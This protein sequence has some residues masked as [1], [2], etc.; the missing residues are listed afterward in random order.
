MK[1]L[2]HIASVFVFLLITVLSYAQDSQE[3]MKD[4][5]NALFEKEQYVEATSLYLR[6]LSLE[7]RS[8]EL[9]YRYGACLLYNSNKKKDA[10]KYLNYSITDADID[11][12]AYFFRGR[13]L[14]LDYQFEE[15]RKQYQVYQKK[16]SAKADDRYDAVRGMAMCNN[17]KKLLT[18]FTDIIVAEKQEIDKERFFDIYSDSKTIGGSILVSDQFQSKLDKKMGHSPIVHYPP[19]AKTIYYSSYGEDLA[20][21]KDIYIC[22]RLPNGKWGQAQL[23]PGHVNTN[24]DE[25]FPY[26]HPSGN[27]LY[28]S[29]TGHNSMGGYDVFMSR[30]NHGDGRFKSPENVDFAIS[31]PDDDL[32][33]VVDSLFENAY[34]ASARQSEAGKLHVYK[35][36]VVRVPIQEIIVMGEFESEIDPGQNNMHVTLLTHSNGNDLG[37]IKTNQKG[38]YSYVF[39]QG[40]KYDYI[41]TL[42]DSDQEYKFTVTLPF[43]DEFRPLKQR[44]V[45]RLNEN[46]EEVIEIENLFDERV[47]GGEALIA[48]VIRKK[49]ELNVNIDNFN[50]DE[51]E[52]DQK[53]EKILADLGFKG[54][55]LREVGIQLETLKLEATQNGNT[56][57][58][59]EANLGEEILMK[60][61]RIVDL[62][63]I[64]K[65]LT[66]KAHE[67]DDPFLKYNLL[68]EAKQKQTEKELLIGDIKGL[69]ELGT[70]IET[71]L[72]GGA[73]DDGP[74]MAQ[75]E[76]EFNKLV[77]EGDEEGALELL[78]ANQGILTQVKSGSPNGMIGEFVDKSIKIRDDIKD[79]RQTQKEY[80][81][82]EQQIEAAIRT[83]ELRKPGARKKDLEKIESEITTKQV[84]LGLVRGG[85][86]K[87]KKKIQNLEIELN[88]TEKQLASFQN[89]MA[90]EVT[91]TVDPNK[92]D[93]AQAE[94]EVISQAPPTDFETEIEQLEE[95]HPE[96][97]GGAPIVDHVEKIK[98]DNESEEE[99]ILADPTLTEL[100]QT[101]RLI[102]NN[103]GTQ[104]EIQQRVVEIEKEL[105]GG[106]NPDLEEEREKLIEIGEE[107]EEETKGLE[108]KAEGI[109]ETTPNVALSPGDVIQEIAPNYEEGIKAIEG[110]GGLTE[111]EKLTETLNAQEEFEAKVKAEI[112]EVE[113]KLAEDPTDPN[114]NG[115][116]PILEEILIQVQEDITQ[117]KTKIDELPTIV[118]STGPTREEVIEDVAPTFASNV[119]EI[120]EDPNTSP[121]DKEIAIKGQEEELLKEVKAKI[122]DIEK[123]VKK[124]PEDEESK[125]ILETLLEVETATQT[126]IEERAK[127]IETLQQETTPVVSTGPTKEEVIVDVAPSFATNVKEI[128]EDPNTSTLEKEIAIKGQEEELLKDVQSKIKDLEKK[129][130][131]NPEDEESKGIL[132]TL[133]EVE[134][135]TKTSIEEIEKTIED[136]KQGEDPTPIASRSQAKE[137]VIKDIDPKYLGAKEEIEASGESP[138]K[139]KLRIAT[140]EVGLLERLVKEK[141]DLEKEIGKNP[142]NEEAITR[143]VTVEQLIIEQESIIDEIRAE[144]LESLTTKDKED[145][146]KDADPS[147]FEEIQEA[148]NPQEVIERENEL[149]KELRK[150]IEERE[151]SQLRKYSVSVDLELSSFRNLLED[152][153]KREED[154]G[155]EVSLVDTTPERKEEFVEELR[156]TLLGENTKAVT[157]EYTK[158]GELEQQVE[159]LEKYEEAIDTRIGEVEEEIEK[160]STPELEEEL[161]WLK[162]EKETVVKKRRR[163]MVSIGELET[164]VI[165]STLGVTPEDPELGDLGEKETAIT[166][167]LEEEMPQSERNKLTKEL[168]GVQ[169]RQEERENELVKEQIIKNQGHGEKLIEEVTSLGPETP[170]VSK[171]K[172]HYEKE[173]KEIEE[174]V[175]KADDADSEAERNYL[176]KEAKRK[177]DDL[178]RGV[179]EVIVEEQINAIEEDKGISLSSPQELKTKKRRFTITIGELTREIADLDEQIKTAKKK[180]IPQLE[181]KRVSLVAEKELLESRLETIYKKLEED[182]GTPAVISKEAMEQPITFNEERK[183]SGS[184]EYE[185]YQPLAVAALKVEIEMRILDRELEIERAAIQRMIIEEADQGDIDKKADKIKELEEERTQLEL[186]LTQKKYTAEQ[187]LPANPEE[188]MKMQNLVARGITPVKTAVIATAL[189]NLPTTGLAIDPDGTSANNGSI[190]IPVGIENPTGLVYR[191]QVGAFSKPIKS[192]VF[193]EFN[194]VSGELI[195]GTNVTRYMAGF[196]N[197]SDSVVQARRDIRSLGYSDAFVVAYC[198]GERISFGEARRREQAG[199]CV[200]KGTNEIMM[201][202]AI[203]TAEKLGIPISNEV[204]EVPELTYNQAP[205]AAEADPIENM[206][207]LFFTVQ[208]GVFN[209][210][211]GS[212]DV[213]FMPDIITIR[214]S[215][216]LIRYSSG[217]FDSVEDAYPRQQYA[218][219]SG[220]GGAFITAY[221]NG[222]RIS[223][224][225]AGRLLNENGKSI[226][227][228]EM[229]KEKP[230]DKV[231]TP[232]DVVRM[233]SVTN[234]VTQILAPMEMWEHR[235]QIVTKKTFDKFPRDVLNRYN[236]EGSF[237]YDV[238]DKHVKSVIYKNAD[239]LPR[240]WNFRADVD[241]VYLPIGQLADTK[242]EIIG[243]AFKD[244]IIPGDFMDWMLRCNYRR[245]IFKT[246]KGTEVRIF[247]VEE[248]DLN[249][250]LDQLKLFGIDPKVI[251]ETED[252]LELE[253]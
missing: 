8:C 83:L 108:T 47:E 219:E 164:N 57:K 129:V 5:A 149:Q 33:Y 118:A 142:E 188:V 98:G 216:G 103:I 248:D 31:S 50:L 60:S 54:M 10:L 246:W 126:S 218:R 171:V 128:E 232:S 42:D 80:E 201:E 196:F 125:G 138:F 9:N 152:S 230:V 134:A 86:K 2:K 38:K 212:K 109:K 46:G 58:R 132:Q 225:N 167:L 166:T 136:L 207:G 221:Y 76:E 65:E 34:F 15:A 90:T 151:K 24:E 1:V 147:Y 131:N 250:M 56:A 192:S 145:M 28:F 253:E 64:E 139:K 205:G 241:T 45:H 143:L 44:I 137:D 163:A 91:P 25:D 234:N 94:V 237:Y 62:D 146:I 160:E 32:F 87:T 88:T 30:L 111:E 92:M 227:Q 244:S 200:P 55:S 203:K 210:P 78:V 73:V 107:L 18:T 93:E 197:N 104:K 198:D 124:N 121:L 194:P 251:I 173:D 185:E 71:N 120:E 77:E 68:K 249:A 72:G 180:D 162:E 144:G 165:T 23:L 102:D 235:V 217:K 123:K 35:V 63:G 154:T 182:S 157:T 105:Q 53:K 20:T 4:K 122:K 174:M 228:S 195:A 229:I 252:E 193:K 220:V 140:V 48:Q 202:V 59:I 51:I 81:G 226:L 189:F 113:K 3:E 37:A 49:A 40:G 209:R 27:F 178:N 101:Y 39:P 150:E 114:T 155:S 19:N 110:N 100:E 141:G 179:Q 247:G 191:V 159:V 222:E 223:I 12:R 41:I 99:R 172:E 14:H 13:A 161:I 96:L 130:E 43:L 115:R 85:I 156:E 245:E 82:T 11:P 190:E 208:V 186:D 69:K 177:R 213:H 187:A 184:E 97:T 211:V 95:E 16:Y 106:P 176:L 79:L 26:M 75:V 199:T 242:Q 112:E 170:V 175:S 117:T 206:I 22:R 135:D 127:T 158:K 168:E 67:T 239:H 181:T 21:G 89:A 84:E 243:F 29:S 52:T 74:K 224:G 240:I 215:N 204:Q 236:A 17:G 61:K 7:P 66:T 183:I 148:G 70:K 233:D 153:N 169:T 133:V 231:V 36:K 6:I 214:L 116:K 119:K 238:K